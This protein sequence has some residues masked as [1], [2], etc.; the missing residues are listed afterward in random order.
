MSRPVGAQGWG[1]M[2]PY[3]V[4]LLTL[5]LIVNIFALKEAYPGEQK[6]HKTPI[7]KMNF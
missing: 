1:F 5:Q 3:M 7:K 4:I 6:L 2:G